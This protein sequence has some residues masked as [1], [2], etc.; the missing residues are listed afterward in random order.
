MMVYLLGFNL[1]KEAKI[2]F[3]KRMIWKNKMK[4]YD[5]LKSWSLLFDLNGFIHELIDPKQIIFY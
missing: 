5:E 3:K 1:R 4:P 2:F